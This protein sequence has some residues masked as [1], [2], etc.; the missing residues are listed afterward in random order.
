MVKTHQKQTPG[1]F[2]PRGGYSRVFAMVDIAASAGMTIGPAIS[3]FLREALG[4]TIMNWIFS[5]LSNVP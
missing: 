3:G 5:K 1:I 4:Y 2:G